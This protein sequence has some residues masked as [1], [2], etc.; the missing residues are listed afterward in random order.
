[1]N[2]EQLY[3]E[4]VDTLL[5]AYLEGT[6]YHGSCYSCAVGQLCQK[7]SVETGIRVGIWGNL[8]STQPGKKI[9]YVRD[10][11]DGKIRKEINTLIE[12]SGYTQNELMKIEYAFET[13]VNHLY[14][15]EREFENEKEAQF[16]GLTAVLKVLKEIHEV[17]PV[18]S[19]ESQ[20][21]LN[22]I[23][24]QFQLA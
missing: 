4:S 7:A 1:M 24:S 9:Q 2:R 15:R 20:E 10:D 6:L 3:F 18:V 16:V 12:A 22:I 19:S 21:K 13:S 8:F 5:D 11:V 23:A 17:E 14:I